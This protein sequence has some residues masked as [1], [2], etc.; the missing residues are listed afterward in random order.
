MTK[1]KPKTAKSDFVEQRYH[2]LTRY[3]SDAIFVLT[4]K[5]FV[6]SMNEA[7]SA[8]TGWDQE[9]WVGKHF[10]HFL[11][12]SDFKKASLAFKKALLYGVTET[13]PVRIKCKKAGNILVDLVLVPIFQ[14]KKALELLGVIHNATPRSSGLHGGNVGQSRWDP[15]LVSAV[16]SFFEQVEGFSNLSRILLPV[17]DGLLYVS[18]NEIMFCEASGNYTKI[19]MQDG[20]KHLVSKSLHEYERLLGH[21]NFFRIHNA[22]LVNLL[23]IRKYVRGGG[24][25]VILQNGVELSVSKRKR[26]AFLVRLGVKIIDSMNSKEWVDD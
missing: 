19:Y 8:T 15:S 7:F 16:R 17:V 25:Y 5:G 1:S 20:K 22:Y 13:T 9:D 4:P 12:P 3:I 14:G 21:H 24:G 10:K 2:E 6:H 18:C 26:S 23:A 11:N